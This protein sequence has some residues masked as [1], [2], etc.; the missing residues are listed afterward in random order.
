MKLV[1][2]LLATYLV[3]TWTVCVATYVSDLYEGILVGF[4]P[5]VVPFVLDGTLP[6][7]SDNRGHVTA[8]ALLA[9][10]QAAVVYAAALGVE[11]T[12]RPAVG[13]A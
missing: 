9:L 3:V 4:V 13:A 8:V 1:R 5:A 12:R 7:D 2:A 10:L 11:R 6:L